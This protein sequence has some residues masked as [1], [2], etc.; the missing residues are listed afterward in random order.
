MIIW[1][2]NLKEP[3]KSYWSKN[4]N[5]V[6]VAGCNTN[7]Q[8]PGVSTHQQWKLWKGN[9]ETIPFTILSKRI[10]YPESLKTLL[11]LINI[12]MHGKTF[13]IHRKSHLNLL[14]QQCH[15]KVIYRFN[16]RSKLQHP[17]SL[18]CKRSSSNLY[19]ASKGQNNLEKA[20]SWRTHASS[21]VRG[22]RAINR[23]IYGQR[24][25]DHSKGKEQ[26]SRTGAG[27]TT[28]TYKRIWSW[29]QLWWLLHNSANVLNVTELY[30]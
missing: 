28:S 1:R 26:S 27:K 25:Q 24:C 13:C 16:T 10:K 4:K 5:S 21:K 9:E 6:N 2:E 20:W 23:H 15:P 22:Q 14:K 30:I 12:S 3:T 7:T 19:G 8:K 29:V 11:K 18:K 17:F